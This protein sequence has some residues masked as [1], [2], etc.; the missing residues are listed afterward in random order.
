[1]PRVM[2]LYFVPRCQ[3]MLHRPPT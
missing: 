3:S 1:M 2:V